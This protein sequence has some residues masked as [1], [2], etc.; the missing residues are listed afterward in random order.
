LVYFLWSVLVFAGFVLMDIRP[1]WV[2]AYWSIFGTLGFL[3]SGY[4]GWRHGIR[5]GQMNRDIGSRYV[6]HWGAFAGATFL[7]TLMI[8]RGLSFEAL[9]PLLLL[10]L[11]LS[12]FL[13]GVHLDPPFRWMGLLVAAGYVAVLIGTAYAWSMLGFAL[14]AAFILSGIREARR[15]VV[16]AHSV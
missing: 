12:Y 4:L 14:A 2:G 11:A 5:R 16:E 10:F 1:V 9:G 7:A 6:W 3:L 8:G 13:T 15:H